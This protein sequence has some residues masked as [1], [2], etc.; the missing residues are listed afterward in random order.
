MLCAVSGREL[1]L[2]RAVWGVAWGFRCEMCAVLVGARTY[3][4]KCLKR[5][6]IRFSVQGL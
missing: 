1:F 5:V 6:Y 3:F 2:G 4:A